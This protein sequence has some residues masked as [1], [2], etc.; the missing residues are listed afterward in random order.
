MHRQDVSGSP[1]TN[2]AMGLRLLSSAEG[3]SEAGPLQPGNVSKA[4]PFQTCQKQS[5]SM[6]N[7]YFLGELGDLHSLA[8]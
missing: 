1:S 5:S 8:V 7:S 4:V 3:V 6:S 2:Q